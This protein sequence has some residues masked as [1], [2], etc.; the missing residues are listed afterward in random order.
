MHAGELE[1]PEA[2]VRRLVDDQFPAWRALPLV[3]VA[4]WGTDNAMYRLG[5]ELVVRLP[6]HE[7]SVS[8]L[9]K[10]QQWLPVLGPQLPVPIPKP[11]AAGAP[12]HGYPLPWAV[13]R[14]LDGTPAREADADYARLAVDLAGFVRA[15]QRI[16]LPDRP[17][18]TSRGIPLAERD[19][20]IRPRIADLEAHDIDTAA[21]T[22]V[23]EHAVAADPWH[24]P[25][26][27][28]HGDLM[29]TNLLISAEGGLAGV[30]D[31]GACGTGDPACEAL[32]AWMS[33]TRES[34]GTFRELLGL[35]D[36][37][38]A[39]ARG[40]ALSCAVMALPYYHETYPEFAA[41]ARQ[42][43]TEVLADDLE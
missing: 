8:G 41:L 38:W 34:R 4:V 14:W 33:L 28:L 23:W 18:P 17:V 3:R 16:P 21:V 31:F 20:H 11:V 2:L 37:S 6:R 12:A 35:D 19:G 29:R 10:E 25:P 36:A 30:I 32:A 7:P 42:T 22:A 15:L 26:V 1:I 5:D 40:W 27:W 39:R 9:Q 13:F 24:G 43:F